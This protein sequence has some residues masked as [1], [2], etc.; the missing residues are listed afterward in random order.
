MNV[1]VLRRRGSVC[2][3]RTRLSGVAD[4]EEEGLPGNFPGRNSEQ[5]RDPEK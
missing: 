2:F 5:P 4:Y 3:A 1:W